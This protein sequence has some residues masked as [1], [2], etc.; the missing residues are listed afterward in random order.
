MIN[1]AD[2]LAQL[3]ALLLRHQAAWRFNAFNQKPESQLNDLI[4]LLAQQNEDAMWQLD[5]QPEQQAA[6]FSPYFPALFAWLKDHA[7][8]PISRQPDSTPFWLKTS[9]G[10]RKWQQIHQFISQLPQATEAIEWCAGKGHL[11]K[12][13]AWQHNAQITSVEWQ[14]TLCQQGQI[15]AQKLG[16]NQRFINADIHQLPFTVLNKSKPKLWLALH[17]CGDLHR[18][19][20]AQASQHGAQH[21]AL[22]PCCYHR[23]NAAHYLPLSNTG[24]AFDLALNNQDLR[25]AQQ[26]QITA[27][28]GER[29][30]RAQLLNWRLG[31]EHLRQQ[32]EPHIQYRAL[33][34]VKNTQYKSFSEFCLWA[35]TQH[36]LKIP[37]HV[38]LIALE[39]YLMPFEK[40]GQNQ[41]VTMMRHD[42]IRHCFR[43]PLELWLLLD[44]AAYLQEHGY[45]V[46]WQEFCDAAVTPRN[47][48]LQ[49][50][51]E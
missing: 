45:R 30:Q 7:P 40:Y 11:G 19:F 35:S 13:Y 43:R 24:K 42:A 1:A 51:K 34:S 41:R 37:A 28:L 47:L 25:L 36:A 4:V 3:S 20:I 8:A 46:Q 33:P 38:D 26:N 15:E 14:L 23:Q 50:W 10:G 48:M 22:A 17:A 9:I 5:N 16:L 21:L 32:I 12:A 39:Y 27:G 2:L 31:Y 49:A 29:K 18:E 6:F 44:K